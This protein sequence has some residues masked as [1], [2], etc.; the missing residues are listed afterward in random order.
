V[1]DGP[2]KQIATA[3][4]MVV[5]R[6]LARDDTLVIHLV[7]FVLGEFLERQLRKS[8]GKYLKLLQIVPVVTFNSVSKLPR[9]LQT[10]VS[11]VGSWNRRACG[12]T[13]QFVA[14]TDVVLGYDFGKV[15]RSTSLSPGPYPHASAVSIYAHTCTFTTEMLFHQMRNNSHEHDFKSTADVRSFNPR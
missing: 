14:S 8:L 13:S 11:N 10:T 9:E 4:D 3:L 6:C 7:G 12:L 2:S 15:R 5:S 1:I